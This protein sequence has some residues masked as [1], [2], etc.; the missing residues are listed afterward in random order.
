MRNFIRRSGVVTF[1]LLAAGLVLAGPAPASH[2]R[3]SPGAPGIGDRLFPTLGNGGYDARH[4]TLSLRY[5]TAERAQTVVGV[6]TMEAKATKSLSRFN[7]DFD[8]DAVSA[9]KVDGRTAA[10]SVQDEELVITPRKSLRDGERFSATVNYT[11]GPYLY[12]PDFDP[13]NPVGLLPFG[14]FTT[15]DGS[16][17]AGQPDLGRTRSTR[18]TT[19]PPTRRPTRSCSTS[20]PAPRRPRTAC[21]PAAAPPAAA[22]SGATRCASRWP[23]SSSSSRSASSTSSIAGASAASSCATWWRPRSPTTRRCRPGCRTPRSTWST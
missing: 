5:P 10:F 15:Q 14:W 20:R 2:D 1:A 11:S 23:R 21:S 16:V 22:P 18:S 17:T 9:V 4:Y 13:N 7:L 3:P 12:T 6:L 8:G 19:T